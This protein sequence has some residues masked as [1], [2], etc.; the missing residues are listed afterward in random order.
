MNQIAKYGRAL[1]VL[2][3]ASTATTA[4]ADWDTFWHGLHV[5]Y[6]RNN[7]WPDPFNEV[8]SLSVVAPF[9]V[10]KQNGWR[11]H[12]TIGHEQFREG[13]GALL[14][15]GQ[16]QVHWIAT[17]APANR[18]QVYVLRGRSEAETDARV[19]SVQHTLASSVRVGGPAASVLVTDIEPSA[20]SGAWA[21]QINR[22]WLE[23]LPPPKLP[24]TSANGTASSTAP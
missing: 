22:T 20:A 15:N 24:T 10:M 8:D 3:L 12:N 1:V 16:Q 9:H 13:D 6:H 7:A 18:R 19:A 2:L 5:G 4:M 23:E 17:Q 14:A 11:L 21:V